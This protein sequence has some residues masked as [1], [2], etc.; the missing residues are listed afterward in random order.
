MQLFIKRN[1]RRDLSEPN[2]SRRDHPHLRLNYLYTYTESWFSPSATS[3]RGLS[4]TCGFNIRIQKALA[5][6]GVSETH[7]RPDPLVVVNPLLVRPRITLEQ[8]RY[9]TKY[10]IFN[11]IRTF[12]W[13]KCE[14]DKR[15][16]FSQVKFF[17]FVAKGHVA[18]KA[19]SDTGSAGER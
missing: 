18:S 14:G 13:E 1:R 5:S 4:R 12:L 7:I 8:F 6:G 10:L 17:E 9:Y 3:V 2:L 11:I 16:V 19:A 15:I